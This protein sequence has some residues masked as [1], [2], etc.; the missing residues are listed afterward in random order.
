MAMRLQRG[1]VADRIIQILE[2]DGGWMNE[3]QLAHE[4]AMRFGAT[5][6]RTALNRAIQRLRIK[7]YVETRLVEVGYSDDSMRVK[8]RL[9]IRLP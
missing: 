2:A 3:H 1:S 7:E 6:H 8:E 9:E 4:L 5:P